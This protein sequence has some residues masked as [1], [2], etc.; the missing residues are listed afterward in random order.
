MPELKQ[1]DLKQT[2]DEVADRVSKAAKEIGADVAD[3]VGRAAKELG[4]GAGKAARELTSTAEAS[5]RKQLPRRRTVSPWA[6]ITGAVAGALTVYFFDPQQG[7]TRRAKFNDWA[8]ARL[9]RGWRELNRL[10]RYS[11]S[12]AS[13]LP[14]RM[15][16]LRSSDRPTPDDGTLKDRIESEV[17]GDP[18]FPKGKINLDV[19]S[20]VA[21]L[22]GA[23]DNAFQI[24]TIERAVYKVP[25]VLGVENLLHVAGTPAPN[26]AKAR[27]SA[28]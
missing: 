8:S 19:K 5:V 9:R 28:S 12:T 16:S 20:G 24:A 13:A 7:R 4:T 10:G 1:V 3:R 26:K 27:E 17:F 6:V 18:E 15:V 14:Q 22:R 11:S 25:G 2:R 23:V 21:T